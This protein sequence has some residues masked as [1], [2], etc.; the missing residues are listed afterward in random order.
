M[1]DHHHHKKGEEKVAERGF[2]N[3]ERKKK[4]NNDNNKKNKSK[5]ENNSFEKRLVKFQ[6]L[7]DYLK[8]N[9]YILDYYRCEWPLRDAFFSLFSWH[10]ETLNIWT[11]VS[12]N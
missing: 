5:K 6:D 3:V 9:E 7:P 11:Y 4:S 2:M 12:I 8:D 1:H 10:N